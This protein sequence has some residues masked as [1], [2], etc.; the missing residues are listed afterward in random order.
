MIFIPTYKRPL[1]LTFENLPEE[2]R[3]NT[4]LV[5]EEIDIKTYEKYKRFLMV[6]PNENRSRNIADA[7]QWIAI[8]S[9]DDEIIVLDDDLLFFSRVENNYLKLKKATKTEIIDL[10]ET[11][12]QIIKEGF[13]TGI[14]ERTLN[15]LIPEKFAYF[16]RGYS[17]T[18]FSQKKFKEIGAIYN[19]LPIYEDTDICLQFLKSG[20][21]GKIIYQYA[22]S[23]KMYVNEGGCQEYRDENMAIKSGLELI[24]LHP[25]LVKIFRKEK[26]KTS[27]MGGDKKGYWETKVISYKKAYKGKITW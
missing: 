17:S 22:I 11:M 25:G 3:V 14:S 19:R 16:M 20:Y 15:R 10:F 9:P 26:K 24:K 4:K 1:Q 7:R 5:I 13:Y 21:P 8:N 2:L 27:K 12:S 18:G 6:I 23:Q